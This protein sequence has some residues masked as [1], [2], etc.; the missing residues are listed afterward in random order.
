MLKRLGPFLII[1]VVILITIKYSLPINLPHIKLALDYDRFLAPYDDQ[2][3]ELYP[4]GRLKVSLCRLDDFSHFSFI[5][6]YNEHGEWAPCVFKEQTFNLSRKQQKIIQKHI[7][8]LTKF[9]SINKIN[10]PIETEGHKITTYIQIEDKTIP[11]QGSFTE[12]YDNYENSFSPE[13]LDL[14]YRLIEFAPIIPR[15]EWVVGDSP[16]N[17]KGLK[18][19]IEGITKHTHKW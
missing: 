15:T 19:K 17:V 12:D 6:Y 13:I 4:D 3:Y 11:Y 7:K 8:N 2:L 18:L 5:N 1:V 16:G 14:T 10:T 9:E